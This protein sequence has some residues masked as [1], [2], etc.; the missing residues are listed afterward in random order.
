[1]HHMKTNQNN[2]QRYI[3][4]GKTG[5]DLCHLLAPA[6]LKAPLESAP[7]M[8]IAMWSTTYL[9]SDQGTQHSLFQNHTIFERNNLSKTK[10]GSCAVQRTQRQ[11]HT[12]IANDFLHWNYQLS[13]CLWGKPAGGGKNIC[14]RQLIS[15]RSLIL[16]LVAN[17]R[18]LCY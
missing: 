7:C 11:G 13:A 15:S 3:A 18:V 8:A 16:I 1:M 4:T 10:R 6:H 17:N 12:E 14:E 2:R 9:M 5:K